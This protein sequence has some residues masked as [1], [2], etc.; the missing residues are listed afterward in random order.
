MNITLENRLVNY[1]EGKS[2]LSK[3]ELIQA[4]LR[5]HPS[6]TASTVNVYL[7]KLKKAGKINNPSRGTYTLSL[8]KAFQPEIK[9][10]LKKTYNK[11]RSE[12]PDINCCV[13]ETT[14]INNLMRCQ[15][16]KQYIVVEV[17][18]DAMGQV[19]NRIIDLSRNV[20]LNPDTNV[21]DYYIANVNEAIIIKPLVS[22]APLDNEK[23][24]IVP[25]LEKLLVDM[26]ID[27][28]LFSD[29]Q[30]KLC[31]IYSNAFAKYSI[32]VAKMKRY[33]LRRNREL[34]L[35]NLINIISEKQIAQ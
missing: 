17:E 7:S 20:F 19:F 27:T 23:K 34:E 11:I 33:A 16:F 31:E 13:W 24:I 22:E 2:N 12:F 14:W 15:L 6:W 9:S 18:K 28:E 32:N 35:L 29:Q 8:K 10:P 25:T 5:D 3:D 4:I 1:F 21:F 26:L 30:G